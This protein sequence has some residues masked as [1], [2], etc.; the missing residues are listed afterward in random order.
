MSIA[1]LDG[2]SHDKKTGSEKLSRMQGI[3]VHRAGDP[4]VITNV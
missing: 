2:T 1:I 3:P 4:S